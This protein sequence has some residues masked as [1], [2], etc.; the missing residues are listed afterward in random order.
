MKPV[1]ASVTKWSADE[2]A[3]VLPSRVV[4]SSDMDGYERIHWGCAEN[5]ARVVGHLLY[6]YL[7]QVDGLDR[8]QPQL[9]SGRH[10]ARIP[11]HKDICVSHIRRIV[12]TT[13][14]NS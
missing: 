2:D 12:S 14:S 4:P 7:K 11:E 13:I 9:L 5:G 6:R 10:F 3:K 1:P 8:H